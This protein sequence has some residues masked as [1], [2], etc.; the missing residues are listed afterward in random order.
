MQLK[1]LPAGYLQWV[2][3]RQEHLQND[4]AYS[5]Y[6][7]DLFKQYKKHLG[8][9][10]YLILKQVQALVSPPVVKN[11]LNLGKRVWFMPVL[12]GYKLFRAVHL[13]N[14]VKEIILPNQYKSQIKALDVV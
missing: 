11:L 4:L 3:M 9:V 13:E 6:T 10:R 8:P 12:A 5:D 14:M 7:T 1:C 2:Q